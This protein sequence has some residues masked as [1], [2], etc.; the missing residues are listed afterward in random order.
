MGSKHDLERRRLIA[1]LALVIATAWLAPGCTSSRGAVH[2]KLAAAADHK[3]VLEVS[4]SLEVL[5]NDGQDT[6]ADRQYAYD[7][8]KLNTEDT[9]AATF[10]RAAVM[11]RLVQQKGLAS[12]NLIPE[13]ERNGRRSREL[14]PEFR[15]GAATRLLGTLYVMAPAV[16]LKHGN[17]ESGLELLE[18]LAQTH[19]EVF[20]NH[21][22]LAEAYIALGD[23]D[24][25]APHLCACLAHEA[26]LKPDDRR[27]LQQLVN[28]TG[29]PKCPAH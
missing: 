4:D 29:R 26:M 22:R 23:P 7:V 8:V 19:P 17:S 14:D 21:L 10:A 25:A 18:D 28:N 20:E 27:L 13:I 2:P 6:P 11:G 9:A 5:I 16:L 1:G 15:N 3:D 24:P 12:A